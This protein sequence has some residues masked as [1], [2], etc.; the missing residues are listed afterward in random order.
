MVLLTPR[1]LVRV[2]NRDTNILRVGGYFDGCEGQKVMQTKVRKRQSWALGLA[3]DLS[4][5]LSSCLTSSSAQASFLCLF[6]TSSS[7][8]T[9]HSLST[10]SQTACNGPPQ[11]VL[12]ALDN[13]LEPADCPSLLHDQP[14]L[15]ALRGV[16]RQQRSIAECVIA[17][18]VFEGE[19]LDGL[20][21]HVA[22]SRKEFLLKLERGCP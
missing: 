3:T 9:C 22:A 8:F 19:N 11:I 17:E 1:K 7:N 12:V 15:L 6:F 13:D 2:P 5:S 14:V 16:G 21:L 18:C 10:S 20:R 4:F